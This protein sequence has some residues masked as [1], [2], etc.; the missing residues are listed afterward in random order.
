MLL[1][2]ELRI[3]ENLGDVRLFFSS[4]R[5]ATSAPK[6]PSSS[7]KNTKYVLKKRREER[8][9]TKHA[10]SSGGSSRPTTFLRSPPPKP[11][12]TTMAVQYHKSPQGQPAASSSLAAGNYVLQRPPKLTSEGR[13]VGTSSDLRASSEWK[14]TKL[15]AGPCAVHQAYA[16]D[17]NMK[18]EP[19]PTDGHSSSNKLRQ[20]TK[21]AVDLLASDRR[22]R[23][24]SLKVRAVAT[25]NGVV[26]KKKA[27]KRLRD[28]VGSVGAEDSGGI[29]KKKKKV[30]GIEAGPVRDGRESYG[31]F[32][33]RSIS[34][35]L[36]HGHIDRTESQRR[37]DGV[38]RTSDLHSAAARQP[39]VYVSSLSLEFP[40]L[41]SD[42]KE[43]AADAMCAIQRN[44]PSVVLQV[45]SKFRSQ[46]YQKSLHPPESEH[47]MAKLQA[48]RVAAARSLMEPGV[49]NA[50]MAFGKEAKGHREPSSSALKL[51]KSRLKPDDSMKVVR[52]RGPSDQQEQLNEKK[53]RKMNQLDALAIQKKAGISLSKPKQQQRNQKESRT[54]TVTASAASTKTNNKGTETVKKQEPTPPP[55]PFSPTA[56]VLK[57]SLGTSLPS[58]AQLKARLAVFGPLVKDS[59]RVYWKSNSCRVVFQHKP[60]AEAAMNYARKNDLLLGPL[61]CYIRELDPATLKPLCFNPGK[62]PPPQSHPSSHGPLLRPGNGGQPQALPHQQQQ[63]PTVQLKSILKKRCDVGGGFVGNAAKEAPQRVT[64]ILDGSRDNRIEKEPPVVPAVSNGNGGSYADGSSSSLPLMD[65]MTS[66]NPKSSGL[67]PTPPPPLHSL[68]SNPP[69]AMDKQRLLPPPPLPPSPPSRAAGGPFP[70]ISLP[71]PPRVVGGPLPLPPALPHTV[72]RFE[73]GGSGP[74]QFNESQP[75]HDGEHAVVEGRN[76]PDISN[77]ML[78]L[79]RRFSDIVNNIKSSLGYIPYHP[80]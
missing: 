44:A 58:V 48:T 80:L 50:D 59:T 29:K 12:E 61:R 49:G 74:A 26:K 8:V 75:Q 7:L 28:D 18:D 41:L 68:L 43:L 66:K 79:L 60:H 62:L 17:S 63:A 39:R 25:L 16:T 34:S 31:K 9:V 22:V 27:P 13:K 2:G 72:D 14:E 11:Y 36:G 71:P 37:D 65:S 64:F 5:P 53:L 40:Q 77:Q 52:K 3:A 1:S 24:E 35:G 23:E 33:G 19:L 67:L 21:P 76:K 57:F 42:L 15:A 32:A 4:S 55:L 46:V 30:L 10:S 47:D 73:A 20:E 54:A 45:F 51:L 38:V 6:I 56:L 69:R 70:S 78:I